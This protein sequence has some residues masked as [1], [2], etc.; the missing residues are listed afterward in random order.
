MYNAKHLI[1]TAE[2]HP[3]IKKTFISTS[4]LFE[5][6]NKNRDQSDR[7][8]VIFITF[9]FLTFNTERENEKK[10]KCLG[11]NKWQG[12]FCLKIQVNVAVDSYFRLGSSTFTQL[13]DFLA[14]V[15][16]LKENLW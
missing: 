3:S 13:V 14:V 6:E 8:S 5:G 1:F 10:F 7:V 16:V 11:L 15:G 2:Y 4:Y 12:Q 9:T